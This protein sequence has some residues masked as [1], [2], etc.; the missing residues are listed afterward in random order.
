MRFTLANT[1]CR[2]VI[3]LV[4]THDTFIAFKLNKIR[5]ALKEMKTESCIHQRNSNFAKKQGW[6]ICLFCLRA[7]PK[8][9][10]APWAIVF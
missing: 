10:R 3:D 9:V 5:D 7:V 6:S 2:L 8:I 4:F 1:I